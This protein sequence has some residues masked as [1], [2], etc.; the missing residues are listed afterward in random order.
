[1]SKSLLL[2]KNISSVGYVPKPFYSS[3]NRG[4]GFGD[5]NVTQFELQPHT[6][7]FT[8]DLD[9]NAVL[10][11]WAYLCSLTTSSQIRLH[12]SRGN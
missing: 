8:D 7:D 10:L 2:S 12:I 1:V 9:H 6:R 11:P 4:C 3:R 5:P